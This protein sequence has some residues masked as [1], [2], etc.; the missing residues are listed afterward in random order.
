MRKR[1]ILF[2]I[3]GGT[4]T[5][6]DKYVKDGHMPNMGYL[7]NHG[8]KGTLIS[9]FPRQTL[10]AWSSIFTGVNPGKHGLVGFPGHTEQ[11][12]KLSSITFRSKE[13]K[14]L[15]Q[16]LSE[17]GLR[18]I[19]INDPVS[20]VPEKING[21][22]VTGLL[23]LSESNYVY[24]PELSKEIEKLVGNYMFELPLDFY[25]VMKT[26]KKKAY[27]MIEEFDEKITT[28]ALNFAR[29]YE[30]NILAPIFTSTD[31]LQHFFWYDEEY[32]VALYRSLDNR[33]K[34]FIDIASA[35][36]ARMIVLSD[37]GFGPYD[38]AFFINTWL[39]RAGYQK[40][41]RNIPLS[42]LS[43]IGL[44]RTRM[45]K[46]LNKL[47]LFNTVRNI[48]VNKG[49]DE[50]AR[51]YDKQMDYERSLA[52]AVSNYGIYLNDKLSN[53][54]RE[55]TLESI[56]D[57]LYNVR[58]NDSPVIKKVHRREEVMWGPYLDRAPDLFIDAY[59]GYELLH[60]SSSDEFGKP[61]DLSKGL[62]VRTGSH[63]PEGIFLAY[64]SDIRSGSVLEQPLNTWDITPTILHM[65]DLQLPSYID[66][67]VIREIFKSGSEPAKRAIQVDRQS[68]T[69]KVKDR[70]R[71]LKREKLE[72]FTLSGN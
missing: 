68:E 52:Y 36:D 41:K 20:Y 15:W 10:T 72:R 31:R 29:N 4:W 40:R 3:D 22:M 24:P 9:T 59:E 47:H 45:V 23:T 63:R 55:K 5:L 32:M 34:N 62:S 61:G 21:I 58:D 11:N 17:K 6:I 14:S 25:T 16:I 54:E 27:S 1:I 51:F 60:Y 2:G 44:S 50:L 39:N 13:V 69:S 57:H 12:G 49:L 37:H 65:L 66:G 71:S 30:W 43:A 48:A 26:D 33:L 19:I 28:V 64:G 38:R 53:G 46:I 56:R 18:S 35:E 67:R 7:L 8:V 70:I 42:M